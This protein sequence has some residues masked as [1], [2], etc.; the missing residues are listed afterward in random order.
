MFS[1]LVD[2]ISGFLVIYMIMY[3]LIMTISN[4]FA[5]IELNNQNTNKK[6][7]KKF[8]MDNTLYPPVSVL[9]PAYNEERTIQQS[10]KSLLNLDYPLYE[11]IVVNDGSKDKTLNKLLE[12]FDVKKSNDPIHV[13]IRTQKVRGVYKGKSKNINGKD[14]DITIVDKENGGK[15][16]SLNMG[17][18]MSKFPLFLTLDADSIL[19]Q[20]SLTNIAQPF[21]ED[22]N[23]VAA[24]GSVK[25]CNGITI[26]DG[27]IVDINYP[28]NLVVLFQILEYYRAFL[29]TRVW[30]NKFNANLIISGAFGLFK[31]SAVVA[32]GGYTNDCIGEDMELVVKLHSFHR[33]N[34]RKYSIQYV[35]GA[36]CWT[37]A[38]TRLKDLKSQRVR[39][40]KG[41]MASLFRHKYIF[42]NRKYGVVSSFSFL[43]FLF[44]EMLYPLFFIFGIVFFGILFLA[45]YVNF[46][47]FTSFLLVYFTYNLICSLG[48][49]A[50][51]AYY[52][53]YEIKTIDKVKLTMLGIIENFGYRQINSIFKLIAIFTY[54]G[55]KDTW[56]EIERSDM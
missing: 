37:Q 26:E 4:L 20:D 46:K 36:V 29:T 22:E 53:E 12:T 8:G 23:V 52:F 6:L 48:S 39:W 3:S 51:E 27:K 15:S 31:K 2:V 19:Q 44:Y 35:P 14:V 5:M 7:R 41:L 21:M 17:I 25:I 18:N 33:K 43:Y 24:G 55:N 11:I 45:H 40:H 30:F 28:K 1:F 38:P 54:R 9:V 16:D 49:I 10:V 34:N 50:L 42:M 56:G 47:F 32:V 13:Q